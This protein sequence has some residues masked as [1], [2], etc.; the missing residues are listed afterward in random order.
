[1]EKI[2]GVGILFSACL[3]LGNSVCP[4]PPAPPPANP[5]AQMELQHPPR[6]AGREKELGTASPACTALL[7]R[8][9]L[10]WKVFAP[11]LAAQLDVNPPVLL[12]A[13]SHSCPSSGRIPA[14]PA[15]GCPANSSSHTRSLSHQ[16][17]LG[18]GSL[19][20]FVFTAGDTPC[21]FLNGHC[22]HSRA[23]FPKSLLQPH[24]SSCCWF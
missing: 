8:G 14:E 23:S 10:P 22:C 9:M 16:R 20:P 18:E 5:R 6:S 13:P 17:P 12:S 15:R 24:I 7:D 19:V 21:P 11:I 3:R 2:S 1:M 4:P